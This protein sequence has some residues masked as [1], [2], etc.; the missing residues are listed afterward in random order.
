MSDLAQR[1]ERCTQRAVVRY[2]GSML[3]GPC[4]LAATLHQS[5]LAHRRILDRVSGMAPEISRTLVDEAMLER[6]SAIAPDRAAR[7]LTQIVRLLREDQPEDA[8]GRAV[9][10]NIAAN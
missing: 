3:C 10:G 1:C 5:G 7:V 9:E 6:I 2:C 8:S 4:F